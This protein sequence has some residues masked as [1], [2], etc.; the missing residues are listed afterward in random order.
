MM[1]TGVSIFI[2]ILFYFISFLLFYA[3]LLSSLSVLT[4]CLGIENIC[5]LILESLFAS[6]VRDEPNVKRL[7]KDLHCL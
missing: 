5:L 1:V 4:M 2:F 3:R 6:R 7:L